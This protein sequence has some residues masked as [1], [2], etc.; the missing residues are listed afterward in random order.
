MTLTLRGT[1]KAGVNKK[2]GENVVYFTDAIHGAEDIIA[3]CRNAQAAEMIAY[4]LNFVAS[5]C[6]DAV[7]IMDGYNTYAPND[8]RL[9]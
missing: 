5:Q 3:R 7:A 9:G 6:A 8:H 2:D 1:Y 4:S